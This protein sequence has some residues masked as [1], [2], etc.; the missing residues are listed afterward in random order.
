M[1]ASKS[2]VNRFT[3]SKGSDENVAKKRSVI[4]SDRKLICISHISIPTCALKYSRLKE[5]QIEKTT[6]KS[7][8]NADERVSN[9]ILI[10]LS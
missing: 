4:K 3:Y 5:R 6:T 1:F 9:G 7:K 10:I 2:K 8:L